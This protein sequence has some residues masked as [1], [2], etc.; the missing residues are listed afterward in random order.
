MKNYITY[1][2][3]V[4][5]IAIVSVTTMYSQTNV[6]LYPEQDITIVSNI[7]S[8]NSTSDMFTSG[9]MKTS[10]IDP[11]TGQLVTTIVETR[12]LIQFDVSSIPSNA[13]I[14]DAKL[15][16]F[17]VNHINPAGS[18][19]QPIFGEWDQST[20]LWNSQPGAYD[21]VQQY[22]APATT[23]TEDYEIDMTLIVAGWVKGVPNNGL[24]FRV[25]SE[26]LN[27]IT[28][29]FFNF[30]SSDYAD[31]TK[32]PTLEITYNT[33][34][35]LAYTVTDGTTI[36]KY[37]VTTNIMGGET[38]YSFLWSN[39]VTTQNLT[40]VDKGGYILTITDA[41]GTETIL[42]VNVNE[43]YPVIWTDLVNTEVSGNVLS[44]I[45][46]TTD[47]NYGAASVNKI[48]SN[49]D[50]GIK[51]T[52]EDFSNSLGAFLEFGLSEA[53]Q[54]ADYS[55]IDYGFYFDY[56][57]TKMVTGFYL[58][59][60]PLA[61]I[62]ESG[63]KVEGVE[64][65]LNVGD[66]YEITRTG[67]TINYIVNNQIFY[68]TTTDATKQLIGD[69]SFLGANTWMTGVEMTDSPYSKLISSDCGRIDVGFEDVLTAI[70]Y[71]GA[72]QYI[73]KVVD[74]NNGVYEE[75]LKSTN[76]FILS[77]LEM[78]LDYNSQYGISIA[79]DISQFGEIC[80][81]K[82][83]EA[84]FERGRLFVKILDNDLTI[85]QYDR[86]KTDAYNK[87]T[88]ELLDF[89]DEYNIQKIMCPF[90]SSQNQTLQKIYIVEFNTPNVEDEL[91]EKFM[92]LNFIEYSE[93]VPKNNF[94][95][96]PNDNR[97]NEQWALSQINADMAWTISENDKDII[98]AVIDDAIMIDHED[99][100]NN[101]YINQGEVQS[102][103]NTI[104]DSDGDGIIT[105]E[106][107]VAEYTTLENAIV[108]LSNGIDEDLNHYTDDII[109]WDVANNDNNPSPP[110]DANEDY[111]MHGTHVAGI[112]GAVSNNIIGIASL[113]RHI[114]ILPIRVANDLEEYIDPYKGIEY[115]LSTN[116]SV[117]NM[118][119]GSGIASRTYQ[120]LLE[121]AYSKGVISVAAAGNSSSSIPMF[122]ASYNHVISVA[123]SND[124]DKI[125]P[126]SNYGTSID[127][128]APGDNILSTVPGGM[129]YVNL[130]GT[131]M[132]SP[133]VAS[134]CALMKNQNYDITP[135]E[136]ELCLKNSCVNV[137][138]LNP[139]YVG[140]MGA[141]R[142]NAFEAIS[143]LFEHHPVANFS[144]DNRLKCAEE[145]V[146]N[147]TDNSLFSPSSWNWSFS[148]GT[149][150]S[151]SLQSP[152]NIIYTTPG[153]YPVSLIVSN[154]FGTNV[155]TET[156]YITV[157]DCQP[158]N[159]SQAN[160][161]YGKYCAIDF[162]SGI[163]KANTSAV[164]PNKTI[165][166]RTSISV[167]DENGD[168][169][170]YSNGIDI[171]D[172]NH[173]KFNSEP[174][175]NY[176]LNNY[177]AQQILSVPDPANI[178]NHYIFIPP[179]WTECSSC[180]SS[181]G[182][183]YAYIE[184]N[185][186]TYNVTRRDQ[187]IPL[188]NNREKLCSV[189]TAIPHCNG[190]D[191]W[192][193]T[194]GYEDNCFYVY[195]LSE[196]GIS[197]PKD[198]SINT[199]EL[200]YFEN[201]YFSRYTKAIKTSCDGTKISLGGS[202]KLHI[203]D[204]NSANGKISNPQ[205]IPVNS[206][207]DLS[208]SP[209]SSY[210]Y[211]ME[212]DFMY[213]DEVD[214]V[215]IFDYYLRKYD[216]NTK[217]LISS[218]EISDKANIQLDPNLNIDKKKIY[219]IREN[220]YHYD[221]YDN[222]NLDIINSPN[223][224]NHNLILDIVNTNVH[225][226][227]ISHGRFPNFIDAQKPISEL[228][229][230]FVI[231]FNDDCNT[232]TLETDECLAGYT[233][234]WNFGD[235]NTVESENVSPITHT[236][237]DNGDYTVS[238][239]LSLHNGTD[240]NGVE[241]WEDFYYIER[242]VTIDGIP[243]ANISGLA[244]VCEGIVTNYY[245]LGDNSY[246][247]LV[248]SIVSGN[249]SINGSNTGTSIDITWGEN[250]QP[251]IL[252]VEVTKGESLCTSTGS[253][254]VNVNPLPTIEVT[255]ENSCFNSCNGKII[256]NVFGGEA[257][258]TFLW[259][260][261]EGT[262]SSISNLCA[263]TY[264]VTVTD[265]NGCSMFEEATISQADE[266]FSSISGTNINCYGES[267]GSIDLTV[268]GGTTPYS[269]NWS[270]E[271]TTEDLTNL[272]TGNYSVT[273]TD[274][275]GCTTKPSI[276]ITQ[277]EEITSNTLHYIECPD[278]WELYTSEPT[279]GT[280]PYTFLWVEG[281]TSPSYDVTA[282]TYDLTITDAVGCEKH[283]I[284]IVEANPDNNIPAINDLIIEAGTNVIWD[285]SYNN[286]NVLDDVI[287]ESGATLTIEN[288]TIEFGTWGV[289]RDLI[290][291]HVKEGGKLYI[292]DAKLTNNAPCQIYWGGI[293]VYGYYDKLQNDA[294][295]PQGFVSITNG[296]IIEHAFFAAVQTTSAWAEEN[297]VLGYPKVTT[298]SDYSSGSGAI[299][300]I[301]GSANRVIFRDNVF[302]DV[303]FR[304]YSY[305]NQSLVKYFDSEVFEHNL[306]RNSI[307]LKNVRGLNINYCNF[308]NYTDVS[309]NA[310]LLYSSKYITVNNCDFNNNHLAGSVSNSSVTFCNFKNVSPFNEYGIRFFGAL[311]NTNTISSCTFED[312]YFG[313]RVDNG[314][315]ISGNTF[316]NVR[317]GIYAIGTNATINGNTFQ[318]IPI[319][320]GTTA[321][322]DPNNNWGIYLVGGGNFTIKDNSFSGGAT[323]DPTG[324]ATYGIVINNSGTTGGT[325]FDNTFS[326]TDYFMQA[327]NN[328]PNLN[329]R[330]NNFNQPAQKA[331]L[332]L[333]S[334]VL[335]NQGLGCDFDGDPAGNEWL[336]DACNPV[337]SEQDIFIDNGFSFKYYSYNKNTSGLPTTIPYCSTTE[338]KTQYMEPFVCG[339]KTSNSCTSETRGLTIDPNNDFHGFVAEIN[340][341]RNDYTSESF[342]IE[343]LLQE[344]D[345]QE[346]IDNILADLDGGHIK[347]ELLDASPYVSDRVLLSALNDKPTPLPAGHIKEVI[348]A[349][350]PVTDVVMQSIDELNL[351]GG[352][353]KLIDDT[354]VGV[355]ERET[356]ELENN[357]LNGDIL[358]LNNKLVDAYLEQGDVNSAIN[359]LEN[360]I[361][362]EDKKRLVEIY[363]NEADFTQSRATLNDVI[364]FSDEVSIEENIEYCRLMKVLIDL[365]EN[366]QSY[367]EIN[368]QQEQIIRDIAET[369]TQTAFMAQNILETAFDEVFEHPILKIQEVYNAKNLSLNSDYNI[370]F[371][372]ELFY[373]KIVPNPNNG[374]M[375][376]LYF[377]PENTEGTMF[378]YDLAG[379]EISRFKLNAPDNKLQIKNNNFVSG[380]YLYKVVTPGKVITTNKLVIFN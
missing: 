260:E 142:V 173:N 188:A 102:L 329:I 166:G 320:S 51:Y 231:S 175:R 199:P 284:I 326:G 298:S 333:G 198:L 65:V 340:E 105:A 330:C 61:Y 18:Y 343:A 327:Q 50:G 36:G 16:L 80:T 379:N 81:I 176:G 57:K 77:E 341:L 78:N 26:Y 7:P 12:S 281:S 169:L 75:L 368:S 250:S 196:Y 193:I 237:I 172:K 45:G 99:L 48:E 59:N 183:K 5:L 223:E 88:Y 163:P 154:E 4:I 279:G 189:V 217:Q 1:I 43:H 277:P 374:N 255:K 218:E 39:G 347:Q 135:D 187:N 318:N 186:N 167:S 103:L 10:R 252:Q 67:N 254:V 264:S 91:E 132:S 114:K 149:P 263:G 20:L 342:E 120:I 137:D 118:S 301:D 271:A 14:L 375:T 148:G 280:S 93:K 253:Y 209:N 180:N 11:R 366:N 35:E 295:F 278:N 153:I 358:T 315:T 197:N 113:S 308:N 219:L 136:L 244:E 363:V 89:V 241:I 248:W 86:L 119:W 9:I 238:L 60:I 272:E 151:S 161:F 256:T 305:T 224:L 354:Q 365:Y 324:P 245:V 111:M 54:G 177:T 116:A 70:P 276:Y 360:S 314:F 291:I 275:N 32:Y 312:L 262:T 127:V 123:A 179:S 15:K 165:D 353:K 140:R 207:Q 117:I 321:S 72:T 282:G 143:C 162:T 334:G 302:N 23:T 168:L 85:L 156:K 292:N 350:S 190:K 79:T 352:I 8:A 290:Y 212:M 112:A 62:Y 82:T 192:I 121:E 34:S 369:G 158:I 31:N 274:A 337:S 138:Q 96:E 380:V 220:A 66:V 299:V 325:V 49:T 13:I 22:L 109:G 249:G 129:K 364:L 331:M 24:L 234:R 336:W 371:S 216:L 232:I 3:A 345:K 293:K 257:P 147:F 286:Y 351:P 107:I 201:I 25:G 346:L 131:S 44:S 174:L 339:G 106:E 268:S 130:S 316:T 361:Q 370:D 146:F 171:W 311:E 287:I 362:P 98:I 240:E 233:H 134:L 322:G 296:S 228:S 83:E 90:N 101:I 150:S 235:G 294:S 251:C 227:I 273:V 226:S 288:C 239:A 344:G 2:S 164:I 285:A 19:I 377:L 144:V 246:N 338:W 17:G 178:D 181:I 203:F 309:Q 236:Y 210:I 126:F 303:Y 328:N 242:S 87:S 373:A 122:P 40:N 133:L 300:K 335:K 270:I 21:D 100:Q 74:L 200:Y 191:Y 53:N 357:R 115:A 37:D 182:F 194:A 73:F 211:T 185:G 28:N 261:D 110:T 367:F 317:K 323:N 208:F 306:I 157:E 225:P 307:K 349:N 378:I 92:Q 124:E 63:Q 247:T 139:Q 104:V 215:S 47:W 269:Y 243:S 95:V 283:E 332:V 64:I 259:N 128:I 266:L 202:E 348:V 159:G 372:N 160:W 69:I 222:Y 56:T 71:E 297:D 359:F 94:F 258:Y 33:P 55:S 141:G 213:V 42:N 29:S 310:L 195:L 38:P 30:A 152:E 97:Y 214:E 356:S 108:N 304:P 267:T 206:I 125:S 170:F 145:A 265:I 52:Y 6:I 68:Q 221:D 376:L 289:Y 58:I 204:F 46:E 230:D 313:V 84:Q 76:T 205:S 27:N 41:I 319:A 184:L 229:P 355:S 155:K